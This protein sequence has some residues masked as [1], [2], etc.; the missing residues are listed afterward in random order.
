MREAARFVRTALGFLVGLPGRRDCEQVSRTGNIGGAVAVGEEAVM[1]NA[2]KAF[3]Q[4]VREEP[5][6]ELMRGERHG[7]VLVRPLNPVI[8]EFEGDA[9]GIG[10]DQPAVGDGD[11][12]SISQQI[13]KHRFGPGERLF[14]ICYPFG[15]AQRFEESGEGSA[16]GKVGAIAEELQPVVGMRG[17]LQT[18]RLK[19]ESGLSEA[20]RPRVALR[21]KRECAGGPL[22]AGIGMP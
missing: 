20:R 11:A 12:V 14:C 5:A 15:L 3:R 17:L 7:L 21:R 8:L 13:S 2:V 6:N 9:I 10:R 4:D 18:P 22:S 19:P 1:A 16:V